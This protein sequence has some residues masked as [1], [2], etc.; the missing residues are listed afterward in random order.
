MIL[1]EFEPI[2]GLLINLSVYMHHNYFYNLLF[3]WQSKSYFIF[4]L[5][6]EHFLAIFTH[7]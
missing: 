7:F 4:H 1:S 2:L 6:S 3:L 5:F